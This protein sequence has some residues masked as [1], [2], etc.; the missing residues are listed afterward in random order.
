[1]QHNFVFHLTFYPVHDKINKLP[2]TVYNHDTIQIHSRYGSHFV[3]HSDFN[4]QI[5][6]RYTPDM[7]VIMSLIQFQIQIHSRH[8]SHSITYS[9]PSSDTVQTGMPF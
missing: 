9:D 8:R 4:I 7:E 2:I 6:S 1:M 3:T 5:Q